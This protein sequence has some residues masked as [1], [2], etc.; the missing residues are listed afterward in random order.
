MAKEKTKSNTQKK[1]AK[2]GYFDDA[3]KEYVLTTP[4]TPIKWCNYVGTL[5]FGGIV[6]TTGG[7]LICKGDPALNRITKYI[8]QMPCSDFKASTIYIRVKDGKNYKVFSPFY[9][10]T[11]VKLDKWE[12]HVGLSY[13]RWN[14]E[15]MGLK[16][17]VTIF[18]PTKSNTLLQD[19]QIT[20]ESGAAKEV[21][22]I[23][24]YEFSHFEAEKQL[25]NADWVPQTMTLKAHWEKDKHLVLEQYA[26]MK[27]DTAVNYV[28][29]DKEVSS[30]D[31][32]RRV[33]LGQNEMGSWAN[34]LSLANKELNN[35]ECDRGDNI[36]A[37]MIKAGKIGAKKTFRTCTQLGQEQSLKVAAKAIKKYR[38]LKNVDKAFDEL[39]KFWEN[40]LQTI[41]VETPDASFNSMVNVHNPRQCHTTKNWS[42]YLSLYQ[43]G[44]GTSR[45]IGY[46]DSSQDLM[47]VMSHMPEE[48]LE[49]AKNLLSVQ[50]PEGNAM[51]QYAPLA[52]AEDNG[53][54]ANA[55]D[56]REKKGKLDEDGKPAFADWYGDD[57]LWIVLTVASYLKETGKMELLDEEIPF[58]EA[59]KKRDARE[60]GTV[61]EHLKRS[62]NFTR[63]HLG[64]HGIPLLGYADWND[65]MNLELGA[66]SSFNTGLYAKA[67][68]EMMDICEA[69]GDTDS[70]AMYK[71]WYED[72]KKAFNDCAWD[73]KWWIRWFDKKGQAYGTHEAKYGKIYC[74]SQS[75][76]VISGIASGERAL[77]GMDS[78]NKLLNT[79][80]GVKS[81]TPGYRG[82]EPAVGGIS[83]YPP[84]AK[85]NGG[86]FL[87]T[88]PWVMIAET[89][90]G[91]GDKAFEYYS[92]INPAAKNV[93]L[94][95]FESEPYCYP[96]NILGDEHK[97]FGMGRN[98]WLSGTSSWTYQAA[99]QFIIGVRASFKGLIIN[100][101]IPS[102]WSEFKVTRK[103]RGATYKIT[104]KNPDHVNKGVVKMVVDGNVID[105]DVAPIFDKGTHMVEVTLG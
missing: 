33:F 57:H 51:H 92:Q 34:P 76:P 14:A 7:S 75:W 68:L 35:S 31:G 66:E 81:S 2:Y 88:N 105:A 38:D 69:L 54:E 86:I 39:A 32:D 3:K 25:T 22:I 10:P 77:E 4:A 48:A 84:G 30:F 58:Y 83:T 95:E 78:L 37:L 67:L 23:P 93:K 15:Y 27:R 47:G 97:Q 64:M 60:K 42:R 44:Y 53:N 73:G 16:V 8:A 61:L 63:T 1:S 20:N 55:G 19:I 56:S 70:V 87:H 43:L 9:V 59:G 5:D 74:N 89:I 91:R 101:C 50:R 82:F 102:A 41:H 46:R 80:N 90:L 98:A 52:L 29:A 62:L 6:D 21:D 100:P 71:G 11:L 49:L 45:G 72:V 12:C 18:V 24:V 94:D 26:Y 40:Y 85:E 96:Q 28:T 36:A 104:V 79:A 13:M 65:C 17:Q 99:T 103:F